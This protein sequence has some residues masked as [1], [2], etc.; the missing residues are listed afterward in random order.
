[1]PKIKKWLG[2]KPVCD[3]CKTDITD[4][5]VDGR[6]WEGPWAIMC[7]KC[8]TQHGVGL[9][10]GKGQGYEKQEVDFIKVSG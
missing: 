6:T 10:I 9:G 3:F 7:P 5:F 2:T 1:M 8:F 4:K